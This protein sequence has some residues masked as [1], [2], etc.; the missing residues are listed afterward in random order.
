MPQIYLALGS[1]MGDR[2]ASLKKAVEKISLI[3]KIN[4]KSSVYETAAAY[5]TDQ[6]TFLNA[7]VGATTE[8]APHDLLTA[9]KLIET[10]VGRRPTYLYGPRVVDVDILFYGDE[11]I[12]T[13][14]LIIPHALLRERSFVLRPLLDIAADFVDPVTGKTVRELFELLPPNNDFAATAD[15]L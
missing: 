12:E 8:L 11:Q 5:V 15:A 1:N 7:A 2:L 6:P 4:A 14:D 13:P 3:A 9:V 10:E